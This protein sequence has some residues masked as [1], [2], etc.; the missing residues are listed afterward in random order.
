MERN[1]R[2]RAKYAQCAGGYAGTVRDVTSA[3]RCGVAARLAMHASAEAV[4]AAEV[5]EI[6]RVR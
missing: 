4:A 6:S 5:E 1:A 3:A 2:R